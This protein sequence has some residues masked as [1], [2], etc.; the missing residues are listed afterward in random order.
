METTP[1]DDGDADEYP[2]ELYD[3]YRNTAYS[4]PYA[5]PPSQQRDRDQGGRRSNSRTRPGEPPVRRKSSHYPDDGHGF[6]DVSPVGTTHS[7]LDDFEI[8]NDAGGNMSRPRDMSRS[9]GT[10][11]SRVRSSAAAAA[12]TVDVKTIRVKLH[13]GDDSRY[14]MVSVNVVFE[15]FLE[16]VREKLGL[17]GRFK[18]RIRDEGDLITMGDRDDW[19]LAVRTARKEARGKEE[20][21][22]KLEVWVQ[23]IVV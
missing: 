17:R 4:N 20:E 21:M 10:S 19:D 5:S 12:A 22:G 9:R 23:E 6:G 11:R 2:D 8:L 18:V 16:R 15:E 7:S 3:L 14:L 13:A 1:Q